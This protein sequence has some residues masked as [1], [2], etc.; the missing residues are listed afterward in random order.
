MSNSELLWCATAP[1]PSSSPFALAWYY[2]STPVQADGHRDQPTL[3]QPP[4]NDFSNVFLSF[5]FVFT[6]PCNELCG[7]SL[8]IKLLSWTG[9]HQFSSGFPM[10]THSVSFGCRH[11]YNKVYLECFIIR[12][13]VVRTPNDEIKDSGPFD[14]MESKFS[15]N[16]TQPGQP[17]SEKQE[18]SDDAVIIFFRRSLVIQWLAQSK[19]KGERNYRMQRI[20]WRM[21][22]NEWIR[23]H[24]Q[25]YKPFL[26]STFECLCLVHLSSTE[27][28]TPASNRRR[29]ISG[30]SLPWRQTPTNQYPPTTTTSYSYYYPHRRDARRALFSVPLGVRVYMSTVCIHT[31]TLHACT[32]IYMYNIRLYLYIERR[33]YS[34][35]ISIRSVSWLSVRNMYS[36]AFRIN[37]YF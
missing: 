30:E 18:I 4:T 31:P 29:D 13:G 23:C 33:T 25:A 37:Q 10:V 35:N 27:Q 6:T 8:R 2:I 28:E 32:H 11:R 7:N 12:N 19:C 9:A 1:S 16:V 15:D 36:R 21:E 22:W 14:G 17:S 34:S 24:R 3:L 20:F 5:T 26:L